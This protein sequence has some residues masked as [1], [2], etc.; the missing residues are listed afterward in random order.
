MG[1]ETETG[2]RQ[3]APPGVSAFVAKVLDQLSLSA[4]LPGTFFALSMSVLVQFRSLGRVDVPAVVDAFSTNWRSV[5]LLTAPV[6]VLSVLVI[7]ASSFAAIQFLEGY[8]RARGPGRWI[9]SGLIRRQVRKADSLHTRRMQAQ[10]RA[11]DRSEHRW[12]EDAEVVRALWAAARGRTSPNLSD[13]HRQRIRELDWRE[14][15]EPWA[16]ARIDE[17]VQREKDLPGVARVL[18]THLGNILRATEDQLQDTHGD[19]SSFALRRRQLADPRIQLQH[20][21]FRTRLEMYCI[22]SLV[23]A[24]LAPLTVVVM[25]G[26]VSSWSVIPITALFLLFAVASYRA[27]IASARGYCAALRVMDEA[28]PASNQ[29]AVSPVAQEA[30]YGSPGATRR[31]RA[32]V[33]RLRSRNQT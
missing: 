11:F 29:S 13:E 31:W 16:L 21:Q 32:V 28:G 5:L 33:D 20:D 3:V 24:V 10:A 25:I 26:K 18:P 1:G 15:C 6:L 2:A 22:L 30:T 7:Q 14:E 4:W 12:D 23:S 27:A 8:G 17:M 19:V 9:R